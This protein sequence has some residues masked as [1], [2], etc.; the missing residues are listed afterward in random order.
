MLER[1]IRADTLT[2]WLMVAVVETVG[3][4]DCVGVS[5]LD[6]RSVAVTGCEIGAAVT[7]EEPEML[8][9]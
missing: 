2:E 6:D 9:E 8:D 4:V 3:E 7:D 5:D 1:L